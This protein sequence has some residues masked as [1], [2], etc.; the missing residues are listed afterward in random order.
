MALLAWI[1][2]PLLLLVA[3][4]HELG[5]L[6]MARRFGVTVREF[7]LGLPPHA[8][9]FNWRGIRWSV[10]WLLP[11]GAFVKLKGEDH[12]SE[13]DDFAALPPGRRALVVLAGPVANLLVA[14]VALLLSGLLIGEPTG[15]R[16]VVTAGGESHLQMGYAPIRTPGDVL[17]G[18]RAL[19]AASDSASLR[20]QPA[21]LGWVGLAQVMDELGD[22]DIPP[23]AWFLALLASLS[24]GLGVM[25]LLPIPPLDGGRIFLYAVESFRRRGP[26]VAPR[27]MSRLNLAG[28]GVLIAIFAA[29]TGTDLLRLL[30]GQSILA[31]H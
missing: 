23:L 11:F 4:P 3:V 7:G 6:L 20:S 21:M 25:N 19:S 10:N 27:L 15:L 18:F 8:L 22:V 14:T 2:V 16:P 31:I 28:L 17:H 5:H 24:I 12:G 1:I 30:S 29:V 9:S 26:V 13:V